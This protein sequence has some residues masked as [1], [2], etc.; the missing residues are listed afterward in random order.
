MSYPINQPITYTAVASTQGQPSDTFTYAWA[1]DDTTTANTATTNKT[2]ASTGSH[3]ATVTATDTITGGSATASKYISCKDWSL[4]TWV[5]T[6]AKIIP[7]T[8]GSSADRI[9]PL[10]VSGN[11]LVN[12]RDYYTPGAAVSYD[13]VNMV[14]NENLTATSSLTGGG[15]AC[16][17][18]LTSGPNSGKILVVS[19][20]GLDY[21]FLDPVSLTMVKSTNT[22]PLGFFNN[23]TVQHLSI[24]IDSNT[25]LF[26]GDSTTN[27]VLVCQAYNQVTDTWTTKATANGPTA[28]ALLSCALVNNR[29]WVVC[30]NQLNTNYYD[31]ASNTWNVGPTLPGT[32]WASGPT[33]KLA[34]LP[35]GY[36]FFISYA[37]PG[38]A[39]W[40]D[41]VSAT[42]TS[43][44]NF[45]LSSL[46]GGVLTN[47]SDSVCE[48][49]NDGFIILMPGYG[50]SDTTTISNTVVYSPNSNSFTVVMPSPRLTYT[51]RSAFLNGR[52]W[53]SSNN[54]ILYYTDPVW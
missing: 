39:Y 25:I 4:L 37:N 34:H 10:M 12:V 27:G 7:S 24:Q 5:S 45:P 18:M 54:G 44:A 51:Y 33:L 31:I 53:Q 17:A 21:G 16:G 46:N 9:M 47:I 29:I 28:N 19:K 2:W 30:D 50:S 52:F 15:P 1:F 23:P 13:T 20:G 41:G 26:I 14:R 38:Q 35:N 36:P 3:L 6:A 49:S 40:W 42:L 43:G 22:M 48:T 8:S 11:L 32:H